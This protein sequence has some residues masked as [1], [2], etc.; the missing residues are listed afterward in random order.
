MKN[1]ACI[2]CMRNIPEKNE[3]NILIKAQYIA[4]IRHTYRNNKAEKQKNAECLAH[5]KKITQE[6]ENR[7]ML[8]I[9]NRKEEEC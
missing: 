6:I 5:L 2:A 3:A 7:K 9:Q 4:H 8:I 1:A